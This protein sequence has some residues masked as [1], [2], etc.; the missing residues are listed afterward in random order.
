MRYPAD[1]K[2]KTRAR[3]LDAAGR[4][5]RRQGYHAAG[6][7]QVMKEAGLTPGGFYSHFASKEALLAEVLGP[8]VR[9]TPLARLFEHVDGDASPSRVMEFVA[10]YL[11]P[12][13]LDDAERG[14]PLP[15]LISEIGRGG[16]EVKA[17]FEAVFR[18]LAEHLI[19]IAGQTFDESRARAIIALCVGGV[20]LARSINDRELA[21][22]ILESCRAQAALMLG[23]FPEDS[24]ESASS[25]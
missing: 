7:D 22:A 25:D 9:S 14:C 1:Q 19:R 11:S 17:G 21:E 2:E 4:V 18:T 8:T 23:L 20:G 15:A 5:F 24:A 13:H 3:I 16:I 6:V 12:S 10:V